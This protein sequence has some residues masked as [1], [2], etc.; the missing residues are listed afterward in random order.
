[1]IAGIPYF[2]ADTNSIHDKIISS[3]YKTVKSYGSLYDFINDNI[4]NKIII[5][6]ENKWLT[7][8]NDIKFNYRDKKC[9]IPY[10]RFKTTSCRHNTDNKGHLPIVNGE[11][12]LRYDYELNKLDI[13]LD[14]NK[15][16]LK[17]FNIDTD[18]NFKVTIDK[19]ICDKE[20]D[21]EKLYR[22]YIESAYSEDDFMF[23]KH[24]GGYHYILR[25]PNGFKNVEKMLRDELEL[26]HFSEKSEI[27]NDYR[28]V[29]KYKY[30]DIISKVGLLDNI[31]LYRERRLRFESYLYCCIKNGL[32][33]NIEFKGGIYKYG[34][35]IK[36][37]IKDYWVYD[38]SRPNKTWTR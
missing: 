30:N 4:S 14:K 32:L 27:E 33:N 7:W 24:A 15:I 36:L 23:N 31:D 6:V 37:I 25:D 20:L 1:M 13:G 12:H 28:D 8:L 26:N 18:E 29:R 10:F 16:E 5:L 9:Y 11:I 19:W 35:A 17:C 38:K 22:L 34:E 2:G 21:I 3:E